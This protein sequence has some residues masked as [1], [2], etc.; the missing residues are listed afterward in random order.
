[1]HAPFYLILNIM[2]LTESLQQELITIESS[3]ERNNRIIRLF[4]RNNDIRIV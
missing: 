4:V 3:V 1:M 2:L